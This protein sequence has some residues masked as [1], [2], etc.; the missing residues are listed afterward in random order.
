MIELNPTLISA[1][2]QG[3][4]AYGLLRNAMSGLTV[5]QFCSILLPLEKERSPEKSESKEM[6]A[7]NSGSPRKVV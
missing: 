5:V 2:Y 7:S 1:V 6:N 3:Y 4:S